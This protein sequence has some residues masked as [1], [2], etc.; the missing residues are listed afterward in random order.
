MQ[1]DEGLRD[2]SRRD[3]ARMEP[4]VMLDFCQLVLNHLEMF[5]GV[6]AFT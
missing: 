5:L 6:T 3:R 1:E 4:D 2:Q